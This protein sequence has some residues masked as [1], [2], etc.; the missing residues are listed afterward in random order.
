MEIGFNVEFECDTL[1]IQVG[2]PR[3]A[4]NHYT[5]M[6]TVTFPGG[7]VYECKYHGSLYDWKHGCL[8]D[9]YDAAAT[10]LYELLSTAEDPAWLFETALDGK[11]MEYNQ[12]IALCRLIAT[13]WYH[14]DEL[15]AL[16]TRL[17]EEE[18]VPWW[19][20]EELADYLEGCAKQYARR[21]DEQQDL[22][23]GS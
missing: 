6:V 1:K 4:I 12:I 14:R 11:S 23:R 18:E 10:V 13:A 19:N 8:P 9:A 7:D 3:T 17:E 22:A 20:D 2:N 15:I 16:A 5:R 21:L